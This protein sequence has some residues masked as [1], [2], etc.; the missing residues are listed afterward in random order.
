MLKASY[1]I[2]VCCFDAFGLDVPIYHFEMFDS[3]L[4]LKL[5]DGSRTMILAL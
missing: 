5:E 3:N 1:V 2:F 4:Q